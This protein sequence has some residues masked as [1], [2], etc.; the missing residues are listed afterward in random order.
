MQSN[1]LIYEIFPRML[2]ET[3]KGHRY[4]A[5]DGAEI[6]VSYSCAYQSASKLAAALSAHGLG[7]G[8][9]LGIVLSAPQA[10][11]TTFLAC[12]MA[13]IVAVPLAPPSLH[14]DAHAYG[15]ALVAALNVAQIRTVVAQSAVCAM[16]HDVLPG[17]GA[18]HRCIAFEQLETMASG[19]LSPIVPALDDCCYIQFTSGSTG[20]P[21]GAVITYRNLCANLW[22]IMRHGLDIRDD[23][24]SVS[25]LPLYHDMGLVGKFLAPLAFSVEMVYLPT[26]AFVKKPASWITAL[27][28][29]RASISFAPNFAY[30]LAAKRPPENTGDLDLSCIRAL[31]C[32]AEP[33][34]P[35]VIRRFVEAFAP[36]GLNPNALMPCY[37]MAEATLAVT[38]DSLC[39]PPT[40]I[41]V[42]REL[43][44]SAR[45][46]A[47]P[48]P[49][50]RALSLVSCG[51]TLPGV[52][53][54]IRDD[55]GNLL[56]SNQIGE[57]WVKSPG[58]TSGYV[59]NVLDTAAAIRG[60]WLKTGDLGFLSENE[61][62]VTGRVKDSII[63]NG[64]NFSAMDFEWQVESLPEVRSGHV[65]AFSVPTDATEGVVVVA[66]TN[67]GADVQHLAERIRGVIY[68]A[69]S[70]PVNDIV[71]VRHGTLPKTTS[72]KI[73][74]A[75]TRRDYLDGRIVPL[76]GWQAGSLAHSAS[77]GAHDESTGTGGRA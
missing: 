16:L 39:R 47:P 5:N 10:F 23:D 64:K 44:E 67:R 77:R 32:G 72:G 13:G 28:R 8:D 54:S 7:K 9:R 40:I 14:Q 56:S 4:L 70:Q 37:G 52:E 55:A 22:A 33:I 76:S 46:V 73:R 59:N 57:I 29:Y 1:G 63:I 74:R 12:M 49:G 43:A 51:K 38:F 17:L 34:N 2:Q 19:E 36:Y 53:I 69:L 50:A 65:V 58:V 21:K 66:E 27:S 35:E 42:D 62:F 31:G 25:W 75:Q 18:Q 11:T 68:D 60:G 6:K 15:A 48:G 71:L 30:L 20:A 3:G 26:L 45:Q 24:V 61:L 41:D